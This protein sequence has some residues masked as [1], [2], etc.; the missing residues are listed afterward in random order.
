MERTMIGRSNSLAKVLSEHKMAGSPV[1]G[2]FCVVAVK[3]HKLQI[4]DYDQLD[5]VLSLEFLD[6]RSELGDAQ[7]RGVVDE[8]RGVGQGRGFQMLPLIW[9]QLS[10]AQIA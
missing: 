2:S 10:V 1:R 7:R 4:V 6:F 8:E 9:R 3:V 5:I